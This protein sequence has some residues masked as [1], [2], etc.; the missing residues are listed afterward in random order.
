[1]PTIHEVERSQ[2]ELA[3]K[4]DLSPYAGKW[5]ALREGKVVASARSLRALRADDKVEPSDLVRPVP[6][7]GGAFIL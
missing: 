7:G 4:E 5:V 3:P 1:M 2:R 6:R